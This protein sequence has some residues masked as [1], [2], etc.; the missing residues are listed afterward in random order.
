MLEKDIQKFLWTLS[1]EELYE[2][3]KTKEDN[4]NNAK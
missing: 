3:A 2:I 4:K 1:F